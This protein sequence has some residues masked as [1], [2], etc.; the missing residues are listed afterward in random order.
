MWVPAVVR[1]VIVGMKPPDATSGNDSI[2][3]LPS[4][5][6]EFSVA[7]AYESIAGHDQLEDLPLAKKIWAWRGP[8]RINLF[9]WRIMTG[10]LATNHERCR[11]HWATS[12]LC[13]ACGGAET[14]AHA[15][16]NCPLAEETWKLITK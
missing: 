1:D 9:L 15:L 7:S 3:W 6:G 5:D 16:R 11:R 2:A 4:A 13:V 8:Y 12:D 14:M 10:C